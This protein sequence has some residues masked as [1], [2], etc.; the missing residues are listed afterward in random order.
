MFSKKSTHVGEH[1]MPTTLAPKKW[2]N[3][4]QGTFIEFDGR[5]FWFGNAHLIN[6]VN[7]FTDEFVNNLFTIFKVE[8][9]YRTLFFSK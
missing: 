6:S 9:K 7:S 4:A 5:D 1:E 2:Y 3:Y 8:H